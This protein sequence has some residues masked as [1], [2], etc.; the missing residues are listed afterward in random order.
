[1]GW[2]TD[3][4]QAVV[5]AFRPERESMGYIEELKELYP[6]GIEVSSDEEEL[7]KKIQEAGSRLPEEE[8]QADKAALEKAIAA[9]DRAKMYLALAKMA[10]GFGLKFA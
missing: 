7:V 2:L 1:M 5:Q 3:L 6:D 9:N 4:L 8:Y 10:V